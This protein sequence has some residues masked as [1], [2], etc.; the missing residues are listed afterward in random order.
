MK[1][2][3][4]PNFE[5][6]ISGR[7]DSDFLKDADGRSIT[8]YCT[9]LC[10]AVYSKK[11]KT[12]TCATLLVTESE[13]VAAVEC[14]QDMLFGMHLLESMGLKVKKP[15]VLEVDNK[16]TKDLA[17][18]W[19]VGGRTRHIATKINFLRE[20]KEEGIIIVKW[21]PMKSNTSDLF[22]KNLGGSAFEWQ[23]AYYVGVDEYM[24]NMNKNDD[25]NVQ[26]EN[27]GSVTENG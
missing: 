18:N 24:H 6:I 25:K 21:I 12:Q 14:V 10:G 2:N 13:T 23:A 3:G 15:M 4:D 26:G 17:H 9:T 27:V 8:G 20:L 1:W 19:S 5:F 7:S 11:S 16:G 22:T